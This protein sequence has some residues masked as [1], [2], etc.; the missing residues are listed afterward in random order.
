VKELYDYKCQVCNEGIQTNSGLYVEAAHVKP[1]GA[2]HNGPDSM[3]N[4]ICLC[5]N[6]HVKFDFGGFTILDDN[7]L[8]G[9]KGNLSVH[10]HHS[11]N[12]EYL[13]YH[14][15]HFYQDK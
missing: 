3:D 10:K 14:R 8:L 12:K 4:I 5:P 15:E 1:L 7:E 6:H 2:P 13:R 9:E 11:L